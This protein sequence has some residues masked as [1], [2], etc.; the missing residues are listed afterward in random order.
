MKRFLI[1]L[2]VGLIALA[3]AGH[4]MS[5][6]FR[7]LNWTVSPYVLLVTAIALEHGWLEACVSAVV[8]LALTGYGHP[9]LQTHL[10]LL[11]GSA[12]FVGGLADRNRR[13]IRNL[14]LVIANQ[15]EALVT[16]GEHLASV[17]KAKTELLHR[18]GERQTTTGTLHEVYRRLADED[19]GR[20]PSA[21]VDV[22]AEC[23]GAEQ[24]SLYLMEG[25]SLSLA[26]SKGWT[27][28]P[29]EAR[30]VTLGEDLLSLAVREKRLRTLQEFP[31]DRLR[32]DGLDSGFMRLMAAPILHAGSG[33]VLGVL[34]VESLPF[35][36]FNRSS[37]QLLETI[38]ELAGKSLT[39]AV[40]P[41]EASGEWLSREFFR[42]RLRAELTAQ[43]KGTR[44]SF[45][46]ISLR[47]PNLE[48]TSP[49][50]RPVVERALK[51]I[52]QSILQPEDVRGYW[53]TDTLGVLLLNTP[54]SMAQQLSHDL[55]NE[56]QTQLGLWMP[57]LGLWRVEMACSSSEGIHEPEELVNKTMLASSPAQVNLGPA[58]DFP[59]EIEEL[60][61]RKRYDLA[62][63][64][65][66]H[67]ISERPRLAHIRHL[68]IRTYL[69]SSDNDSLSLAS[70]QYSVTKLLGHGP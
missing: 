12:L 40:S 49:T 68:L 45:S 61:S 10:V 37:A 47:L 9:H 46:Y 57:D 42:R 15:A 24:C 56:L 38:A 22:V 25:N 69:E 11:F 32:Y 59:V 27:S 6:D 21:I 30:T 7:Y 8:V 60:K 20:L 34:S 28:T 5:Y 53:E 41:T 39:A 52:L 1:N 17:E 48:K 29:D 54:P 33:A 16:K 66:R 19:L 70:E 3:I 67:M 4:I 51:L 35:S 26:M 18:L 50:R 44:A 36:L 64:R 62:I 63:D 58:L 55:Q 43:Q 14:R 13:R 2:S 65:L 31:L 23:I